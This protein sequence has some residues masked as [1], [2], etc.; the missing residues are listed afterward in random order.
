M[1]SLLEQLPLQQNVAQKEVQLLQLQ[2]TVSE[3][4]AQL[5]KELE[6]CSA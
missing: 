2:S 5:Q 1:R 4:R 3:L 6:V